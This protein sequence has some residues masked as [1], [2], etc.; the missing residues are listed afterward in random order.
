M[1]TSDLEPL[2]QKIEEENEQG[3]LMEKEVM[4]HTLEMA[5]SEGHAKELPIHASKMKE[6]MNDIAKHYEEQANGDEIRSHIGSSYV[7]EKKK[8]KQMSP[9]IVQDT[10]KENPD[11]SHLE[12]PETS[13]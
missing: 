4:V 3:I 8:R 13:T 11:A 6:V 7:C 12:N 9:I 1:T 10:V 2:E 5:T